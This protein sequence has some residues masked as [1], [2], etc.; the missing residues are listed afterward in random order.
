MSVT[1]VVTHMTRRAINRHSK[2][3]WNK[4]TRELWH[5]RRNNEKDQWEQIDSAIAFQ[6]KGEKSIPCTLRE[7]WLCIQVWRLTFETFKTFPLKQFNVTR[8]TTEVRRSKGKGE[9]EKEKGSK[10]SACSLTWDVWV[11]NFTVKCFKDSLIIHKEH[12]SLVG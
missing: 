10:S 9:R 2:S 3:W 12:V 11:K 6:M 8:G 1:W 7:A 4:W 5:I